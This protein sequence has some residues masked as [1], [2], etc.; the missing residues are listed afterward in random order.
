MLKNLHLTALGN[1]RVNAKVSTRILCMMIIT[2]IGLGYSNNIMAAI[3]LPN[4]EETNS[5]AE[6]EWHHGSAS[7]DLD[8]A[9][10]IDV[11][12]HNDHSFVLRQNKCLS[13]EAPFIYVL[14]GQNKLLIL[15][16]G[17]TADAKE[18]PLYSTVQSLIKQRENKGLPS[19]SE[20]LV[21]HSHGH[22][23]HYAGDSQFFGK[24]STTVVTPEKA[25]VTKFF[26]FDNSASGLAY[27]DLGQR[28]LTV[29]QTPGHQEESISVYDSQTQ[30]LM[31][32]DT[33]YPGAIY[34]KHWQEYTRSIERLFQFS[35]Q[36]EI[37]A[38]L[39]AHIEMS[40]ESGKYYPIGTTY[41]PNEASLSL[42]VNDLAKLNTALMQSKKAQKIM[43]NHLVIEPMGWFQKSVSNIIRWSTQ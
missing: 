25:A 32:G 43:L 33:I 37:S 1:Y 13:Y 26:S 41:Q 7:C 20:T 15:D 28:V 10:A 30:W 38:I 40:N 35:Q 11:F 24:P 29:I 9:P 5:I 6:K 8:E 2:M 16:T 3:S 19:P 18:F 39:G 23:D 34:V 42:S 31:T 22:S 21:I 36:H 14:F 12:K 27:I 17:A 4:N